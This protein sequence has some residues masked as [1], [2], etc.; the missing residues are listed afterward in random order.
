MDLIWIHTV[1]FGSLLATSV[2]SPSPPVFL[3]VAALAPLFVI[4]WSVTSLRVRM[5]AR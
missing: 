2:G 5:E 3:A 1:S 4:Q